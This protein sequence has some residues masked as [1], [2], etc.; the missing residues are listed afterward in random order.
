[1]PKTYRKGTS[2]KWKFGSGYGHGKV[3]ASHTEKVVR[4]IDGKEITRNGS[5]ENP[6]YD[7]DSD[8]GHDVL[9]L[10]DEL[11]KDDES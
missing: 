7:I 4:K 6:A 2:V 8:H 5:P 10:H 3:K 11:E 9:K 1:M